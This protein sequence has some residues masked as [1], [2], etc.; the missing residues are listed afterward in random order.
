M[1][2]NPGR[3]V[4]AV[5]AI[6]IT[7]GLSWLAA[8]GWWGAAVALVVCVVSLNRFFF[9]SHYEIDETGLTA[10]SPLG[11]K[12]IEWSRVRRFAHND[13]GGFLGT[14]AGAPRVDRGGVELLFDDDPA[15][16]VAAIRAARGSVEGA[17]E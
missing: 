11:V 8:G 15:T 16:A 13:T 1:R 7:T 9:P 14:R 3:T 2:K 12:R 4:F 5:V 6:G 17:A 10:R